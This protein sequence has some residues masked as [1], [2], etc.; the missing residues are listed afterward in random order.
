MKRWTRTGAVMLGLLALSCASFPLNTERVARGY[1]RLDP[2]ALQPLADQVAAAVGGGADASWFSTGDARF[3]GEWALVTCQMAVI[4][5]GQMALRAPET[6]ERYQHALEGCARWLITPEARQ[7]GTEGWGEDGLSPEVLQGDHVHAYLGWTN[8]ALALAARLV[9]DPEVRETHRRL[10]EAMARRLATLPVH[11]LETYPGE[12]YPPDQVMVAASLGLSGGHEALLSQW[13]RSFRQAA[14]DPDTGLLHQSLSP[15]DGHPTD[16]PRGSGSAL[17]AAFL[18]YVDPA[19]ARQLA[20]QVHAQLGVTTLGFGAVREVPHGAPF[21]M[22][23]DSGPVIFGRGVSATGF[24]IAAARVEGDE[25]WFRSLVRTAHTVGAPRLGK[26][27][28]YLT[29]GALGNA[30]LLAMFTVG[31][32]PE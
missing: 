30:I 22:D 21:R 25:R 2:R 20:S 18:Q 17:A 19:L 4:G 6:R 8:V 32:L 13:A 5:L 29:G 9:P 7:F 31:P 27:R 24:S 3:D 12:S 28:W 1:W 23:I 11:R 14:I 10:T 15:R 26:G 16:S